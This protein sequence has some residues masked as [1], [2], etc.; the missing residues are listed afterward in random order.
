MKQK[1]YFIGFVMLLSGAAFAQNVVT[2]VI[3]DDEGQPLVG[4]SAELKGSNVVS[5]PRAT[6]KSRNTSRFLA[7]WPT[8]KASM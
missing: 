3:K 4:A 1:L 5:R 6:S 7:R 2:G 8:P